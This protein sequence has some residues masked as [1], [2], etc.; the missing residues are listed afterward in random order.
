[1]C[2]GFRHCDEELV[3][4]KESSANSF[5]AYNIRL[6]CPNWRL[7]K[8]WHTNKS[9]GISHIA[10]MIFEAKEALQKNQES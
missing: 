6:K 8:L 4:T 2:C 5:F 10:I 7:W 1:M 9:H 3:V